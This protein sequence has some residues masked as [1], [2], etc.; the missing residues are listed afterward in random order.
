[1]T[2]AEKD[3]INLILQSPIYLNGSY[4]RQQKI[5]NARNK[6][7]LERFTTVPTWKEIL[8]ELHTSKQ[9]A[10]ETYYTKLKELS[11][12]SGLELDELKAESGLEDK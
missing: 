3:L 1:M 7:L 8:T 6:V 4:Q 9:L 12:L 2:E 11:K 10:V 5:T